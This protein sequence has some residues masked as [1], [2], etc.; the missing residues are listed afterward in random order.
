MPWLEID[1]KP[2]EVPA[3]LN[4]IE[5][6][7]LLNVEIP[8][9][10]YH[11]GLTV[12]GSC[13]MCQV[14]VEVGGRKSVAI[15]CNTKAA[16]GMK[17]TTKSEV[18]HKLRRSILEFY[19]QH[20]PLD[21]PICDDAGE[22]DLQNYYME[23]G[24]HESRVALAEKKH[25]HKVMDVGPTVVLDSERCVLCSRCVRF[26]REIVGSDELGI[27]NHG[28]D[29]ELLNVPGKQLDNDYAGNVVDLCP[30]G[31]LT[32]K[33]FRFKRRVWYMKRTASVC[34]GCS[35]GCNV[36][37][38]W[39]VDRRYKDSV[40]RVQRLK[41]R[42]NRMVNEW[43]ICDQGRYSY[44]SVDAPNRVSVPRVNVQGNG[45]VPT[46]DEVLTRAA[47]RIEQTMEKHGADSI[48]VIG[49]AASSNED[50]FLLNRLFVD[51][52]KVQNVDV[53][54][55]FEKKGKEDEILKRA[56]LAPNRRGAL[57]LKI[58][59]SGDG[60]GGDDLISAAIEG[61]FEIVIVIRHD[62]STLLSEKEL[63]KLRKNTSYI[64]YLA[65][66]ENGLTEIADDVLP[67]AMWAERE[68]TYTN[69]QGRVQKT[70]IPFTPR[71]LAVPE[72]ELWQTLGA[73]LGM[74][75]SYESTRDVFNALG[76]SFDGFKDLTW[77]SLGAGGKMLGN[78]PEPAY[79]RVQ[80]SRPL[81]AY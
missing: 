50:L 24:L 35:R 71:G 26:C 59:P 57:E 54:F 42:Y 58:A 11:A 53:T 73:K 81:P 25:K 41:P 10:C 74:K 36:F 37:V 27:F 30:V 76:T 39:E 44:H 63:A 45:H 16:D 17:I 55:G 7:R 34:T 66:H 22:C 33:D 15:A 28:R 68:A 8:H 79:R 6:A 48:A 19:L 61:E 9:Y 32:D 5:A 70:N 18:V 78:A 49:S 56:D 4:I 62:L 29:N 12:V 65:S 38:D 77:D 46:V 23:H 31:A 40:R 51:K 64:L 80:T 43:W 3:G 75:A 13:R 21:C 14:E 2:V 47:A 60:Q 1:G 67:L 72:W 52:L 20:H 69:F